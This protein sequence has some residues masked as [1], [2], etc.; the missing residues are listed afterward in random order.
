MPDSQHLRP[1]F[2]AIASIEK[3]FI[4][5]QAFT[6]LPENLADFHYHYPTN[7]L[8]VFTDSSCTR[9]SVMGVVFYH[10]GS[11]HNQSFSVP[12]LPSSTRAE[13]M[14][15]EQA[16]MYSPVDHNL[17]IV[18]DLKAAIALIANYKSWGLSRQARHAHATLL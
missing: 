17:R 14:A 12:S 3:S 10:K 7:T 5:G 13:L 9:E 15:I 11:P 1:E 18:T 2:H 16:L 4:D 8:S 6:I